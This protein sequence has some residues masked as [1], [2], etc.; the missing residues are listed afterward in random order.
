VKKTYTAGGS[1]EYQAYYSYGIVAV[2]NRQFRIH[3]GT[4]SSGESYIDGTFDVNDMILNENFAVYE[5]GNT[6]DLNYYL[7]GQILF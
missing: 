1:Y 7:S 6:V 5:P 4:G 2:T 3:L